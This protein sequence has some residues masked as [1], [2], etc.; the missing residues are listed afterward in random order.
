VEA[1]HTRARC[2]VLAAAQNAGDDLLNAARRDAARIEKE[3]LPWGNAQ[4]KLL[5]AA[6]AVT[7]K[8][9]LNQH[10]IELLAEAEQ[11]FISLNLKLHAAAARRRRGELIA[12]ETGQALVQ[13]ADII[14]AAAG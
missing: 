9:A 3:R 8:S 2:A 11:D 14:M 10:A 13:T 6:I 7:A 12:G 5:R 4:A 1:L